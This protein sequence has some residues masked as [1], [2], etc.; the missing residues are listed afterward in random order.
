MSEPIYET[1]DRRDGETGKDVPAP[2]AA[3]PSPR[4]AESASSAAGGESTISGR[5]V[6]SL[7]AFILI[8]TLCLLDLIRTGAAIYQGAPMESPLTRDLALIA[9][10]YFFNKTSPTNPSAK[11]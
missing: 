10:G 2:V 6:R 7:L 1:E 3:S 9:L 11:G 8:C 5:S 4:F